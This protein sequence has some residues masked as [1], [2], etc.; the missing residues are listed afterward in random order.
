MVFGVVMK[1]GVIAV[2]A[3]VEIIKTMPPRTI[4]NTMANGARR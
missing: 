1:I 3:G 4:S 2:V